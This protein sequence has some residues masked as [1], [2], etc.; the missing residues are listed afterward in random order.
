MAS[1]LGR[2][3]DRQAHNLI[4]RYVMGPDFVSGESL[5]GTV[6]ALFYK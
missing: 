6:Q 1:S 3:A 4:G 2:L 5:G